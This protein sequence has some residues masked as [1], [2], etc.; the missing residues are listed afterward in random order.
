MRTYLTACAAAATLVL[1]GCGGSDDAST[2][3]APPA[4]SAAKRDL[5]EVLTTRMPELADLD[6]ASLAPLATYT[7]E[8][9]GSTHSLTTNEVVMVLRNR[10]TNPDHTGGVKLTKPQA[11]ALLVAITETECPDHASAVRESVTNEDAANKVAPTAH[12]AI[13]R[14]YW[15]CMESIPT[16]SSRMPALLAGS[17]D[18]DQFADMLH[19]VYESA[20]DDGLPATVDTYTERGMTDAADTVRCAYLTYRDSVSAE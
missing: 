16:A 6:V 3:S 1:T 19:T 11:G 13:A 14:L 15:S 2:S 9:L 4:S 18:L 5:A 12:E 7:C 17:G 20:R 8:S 10:A